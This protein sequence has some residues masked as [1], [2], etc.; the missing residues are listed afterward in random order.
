MLR[1]SR[2]RLNVTQAHKDPVLAEQ[3]LCSLN[4]AAQSLFMDPV[5]MALRQTLSNEMAIVHTE[6]EL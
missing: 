3:C 1:P 6:P 5:Q 2:L 4:T